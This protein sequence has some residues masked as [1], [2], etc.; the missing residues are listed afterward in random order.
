WVEISST[1]W[2]LLFQLTHIPHTIIVIKV[3]ALNLSKA[4]IAFDATVI[5]QQLLPMG[6][7]LR[8]ILLKSQKPWKSYTHNSY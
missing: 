3:A 4:L 6:E 5:Y 8:L 2:K 1:K 7:W